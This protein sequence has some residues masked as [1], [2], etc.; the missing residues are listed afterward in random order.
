MSTRRIGVPPAVRRWWP[1][2]ALLTGVG[3][4]L[5]YAYAS[6]VQPAYEAETI[7]VAESRLSDRVGGRQAA[8]ALVPTYAEL[9]RTAP[10]LEPTIARLRLPLTPAELAPDVR[11]ES[12]G[13]TRLLTIRARNQDPAVATAWAN[14]RA[15]K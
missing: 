11:G 7:L 2:I 8:G 9:V 4:F 12:D 10:I 5:G 3:G 14:S 6:D 15:A 1:L 13:E